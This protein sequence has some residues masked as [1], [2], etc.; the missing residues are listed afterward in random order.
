MKIF[1]VED[2][3]LALQQVA[4]QLDSL[5]SIWLSYFWQTGVIIWRAIAI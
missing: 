4:Q 5:S 2:R 3:H 1:F